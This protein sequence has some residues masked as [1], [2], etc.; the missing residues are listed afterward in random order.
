MTRDRREKR[1]GEKRSAPGPVLKTRKI[2]RTRRWTQQDER[3]GLTTRPICGSPARRCAHSVRRIT[4]S[5]FGQFAMYDIRSI[6]V[7]AYL[8]RAST[9]SNGKDS[10]A[11]RARTRRDCALYIRSCIVG[12]DRPRSGG[13]ESSRFLSARCRLSARCTGKGIR[14][15]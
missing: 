12:S 6:A 8:S 5:A 11:R 1:D 15:R 4:R 3:Y 9:G 2:S 14:D 10:A 7:I 13:S